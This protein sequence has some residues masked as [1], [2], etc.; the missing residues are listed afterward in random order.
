MRDKLI[1]NNL[2]LIY[3]V[4][5]DLHCDF[6]DEENKEDI[7]YQGL[8]GLIKAVDTY[9]ETKSTSKYFYI[10]IANQIKLFFK[11]KTAQKRYSKL[12]SI[13]LDQPYQGNDLYLIDI[14]PS[15]EN[16]EENYI[17]KDTQERVRKALSKLKNKLE[18]KC[19]CEY[20]GIGS[21]AQNYRQMARKYGV[22][23]QCIQQRV[24]RG[25]KNIKKELEKEFKDEKKNNEI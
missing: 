21:K 20:Y 11:L 4:M 17:K 5:K 18:L 9:D 16:I 14:L 1:L 10:C 2:G 22:S 13:S 19:L 25:L 12:K 24:K 15:E 6:T 7:Y 3:K 23:Y 8:I